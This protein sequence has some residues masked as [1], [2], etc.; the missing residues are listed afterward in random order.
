MTEEKIFWSLNPESGKLKFETEE[1]YSFLHEKGYRKKTFSEDDL[2]TYKQ[3]GHVVSRVYASDQINEL[4]K[5]LRSDYKHVTE[6]TIIFPRKGPVTFKFAP[7]DILNELIDYSFN[8]IFSEKNINLHRELDI[9]IKKHTR[10]AAY[11]YFKNGFVEVTKE[12]SKFH[13]YDA[14]QGLYVYEDHIINKDISIIDIND[15]AI[16]DFCSKGHSFFHFL[17]SVAGIDDIEKVT[18]E[19]AQKYKYLLE[20][21]GFLLHDYKEQG[22]TDYCVIFCDDN[23]GGSGKGILIQ[24]LRQ[25]TK[26]TEIDAKKQDQ[27]DPDDLTPQTRI[28]VYS[29]IEPAFHFPRV[30]NEITEGITYRHMYKGT[31]TI[32]YREG[33]KTAFT[34]NHIVRGNNDTDLRRQRTFLLNPF[35]NKENTPRDYYGHGFFSEDWEPSDWNYFY[36]IMFECVRFWLNANYKLTFTDAEYGMLKM[37]SEYPLE[38]R[39]YLDEIIDKIKTEGTTTL[40]SFDLYNNFK[41]DERFRALPFVKA[42]TANF[43]GR[44]YKKYFAEMKV[45]YKE[46][47]NRTE[48]TIWI[49]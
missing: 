11:F 25:M 27:F 16:Q 39:T 22:S 26:V 14:M 24:S 28:K 17:Q 36:N 34:S 37:Q 43:F 31:R 30:Y 15:T 21:I 8:K 41:K 42:L 35:F 10:Q 48:I 2:E 49:E 3:N 46:N 29:D 13:K 12:G 18:P 38:M 45:A 6:E 4:V 32:P 1:I 9:R 19:Q 20:C 47:H 33:W 7:K 5:F 23:R 44:H 40:K